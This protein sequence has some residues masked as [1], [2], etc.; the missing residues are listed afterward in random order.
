M[1]D[2]EVALSAA[3]PTYEIRFLDSVNATSG[4]M[5]LREE[6]YSIGGRFFIATV[7]STLAGRTIHSF[8]FWP[9][10]AAS[11]MTARTLK[12]AVFYINHWDTPAA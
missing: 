4:P 9:L 6:H 7:A 5:K 12:K 2:F 10:G 11:M 8:R 3:F 1:N